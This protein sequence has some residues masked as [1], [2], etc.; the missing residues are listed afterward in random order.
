MNPSVM[1]GARSCEPSARAKRVAAD[2]AAPS[3]S[4]A[5]CGRVEAGTLEFLAEAFAVDSTFTEFHGASLQ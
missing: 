1:K 2:E 5:S 3:A 4:A